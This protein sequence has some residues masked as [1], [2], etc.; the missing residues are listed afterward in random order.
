MFL[1]NIYKMYLCTVRY[2]LIGLG[3]FDSVDPRRN[4]NSIRTRS[5]D[6]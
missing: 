3:L 6:L 5:M 2:I 1:F 4:I